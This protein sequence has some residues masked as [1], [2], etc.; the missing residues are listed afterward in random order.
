MPDEGND[1][2]I[3]EDDGV[4]IQ[5]PEVDT[6]PASPTI[7][8]EAVLGFMQS[9][10]EFTGRL[11]QYFGAGQQPQPQAP[12]ETPPTQGGFYDDPEG[13]IKAQNEAAQRA[14][15]EAINKTFAPLI[16]SQASNTLAGGIVSEFNLPREAE[17]D[18]RQALAGLPPEQVFAMNTPQGGRLKQVLADAVVG[19]LYREGRMGG[20]T[21]IT[22]PTTPSKGTRLEYAPGYDKTW[23]ENYSKVSGRTPTAAELRSMGVIK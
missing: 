20:S 2:V 4:Y 7:N 17:A 21:G 11:Q 23:V 3:I 19:K 15:L 9:N 14:T 13:F 22:T 8:E 10:P 12:T 5:E 6:P 18:V 1:Q 16:A